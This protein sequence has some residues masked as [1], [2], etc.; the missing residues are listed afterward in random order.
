MELLSPS[1]TLPNSWRFDHIGVAVADMAEARTLLTAMLGI[2]QW[3]EIFEDHGIGVYVQFGA[4]DSGPSYELIAPI[5]VTSPIS[6]ALKTG[7]GI[8]NHVAYLV[9]DISSGAAWLRELGCFPVAEAQPAVAYNGNSVQFFQSPLR[10]LVELIEA[11]NHTH[12]FS[13]KAGTGQI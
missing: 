1:E 9:P 12:T 6:G 4:A 13:M 11:T 2:T 8:L 5:N 7:K 3:S 10:F